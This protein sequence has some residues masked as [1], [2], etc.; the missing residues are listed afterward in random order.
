MNLKPFTWLG[1]FFL[2]FVI[3]IIIVLTSGCG[4]ISQGVV[5]EKKYEPAQHW[6]EWDSCKTSYYV[7]DNNGD[8]MMD[9]Q[10]IGGYE[11]KYDDEDWL[12]KIEACEEKGSPGV[13]DSEG[14][15][16]YEKK[17]K[18]NWVMVNREVYENIKPGDYFDGKGREGDW[19]SDHRG[20]GF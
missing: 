9:R 10:C 11:D 18:S 7:P 4:G 17:C 15:N 3:G 20:W 12:I 1:W 14:K 5:I 6:E 19:D 2:F 16:T 13:L 8:G